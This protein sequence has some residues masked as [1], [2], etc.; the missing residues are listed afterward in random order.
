MPLRHYDN[1]ASVMFGRLREFSSRP[2]LKLE[3]FHTTMPMIQARSG[4]EN[5]VYMMLGIDVSILR[6]I[7]AAQP[8]QMPACM[9][10]AILYLSR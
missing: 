8:E 6:S 5:L 9:L 3:L 7:W 4:A 10:W 1:V 2:W